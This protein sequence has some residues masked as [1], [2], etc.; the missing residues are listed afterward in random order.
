MIKRTKG[1][2]R[3]NKTMAGAEEEAGEAIGTGKESTMVEPLEE[4]V[5][6]GAAEAEE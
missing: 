5:M 4:E 1:K 3:T 6:V 2:T